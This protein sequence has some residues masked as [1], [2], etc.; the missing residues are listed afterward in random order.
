MLKSNNRKPLLYG[1]ME[2]V[3]SFTLLLDSLLEIV[4]I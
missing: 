3:N 4:N 1:I 2:C